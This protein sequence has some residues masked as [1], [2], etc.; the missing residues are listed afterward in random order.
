MKKQNPKDARKFFLRL[1]ATL[2]QYAQLHGS[3]T[4]FVQK[5]EV[6]IIFNLPPRAPLPHNPGEDLAQR[7]MY[8]R[9][10]AHRAPDGGLAMSGHLHVRVFEVHRAARPLVEVEVPVPQQTGAMALIRAIYRLASQWGLRN[11]PPIEPIE[12]VRLPREPEPST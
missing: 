1:V 5:G 8:T 9:F 4:E 3:L 12:A 11:Y 7:V 6:A 2:P 10:Y